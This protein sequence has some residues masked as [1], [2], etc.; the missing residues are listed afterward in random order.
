MPN[1]VPP[2]LPPDYTQVNP[3][4]PTGLSLIVAWP[5]TSD[6]FTSQPADPSAIAQHSFASVGGAGLYIN[7]HERTGGAYARIMPMVELPGVAGPTGDQRLFVWRTASDRELRLR[8]SISVGIVAR[9]GPGSHAYGHP[10][11]EFGDAVSGHS[12]L[13]TI[14]AYGTVPPGDFTAPDAR[15]GEPIVST[16]FRPDPAFGRVLS[17]SFAPCSGDGSICAPQIPNPHAP[18]LAFSLQRA[19][20]QAAIDRA[21]TV[22]PALSGKPADYFLARVAFNNETY[23]DARLGVTLIDLTAEIWYVE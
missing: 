17:G 4:Y 15:S 5:F 19:D 14:Q 2:Y 6:L 7:G 21:R 22:D 1:R 9:D 23:L 10:M 11:L 8:T 13:V 3:A 12:F 20:F 16:V 18:S